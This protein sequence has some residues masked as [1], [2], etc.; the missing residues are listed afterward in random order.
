MAETKIEDNATY[1]AHPAISRTK[2]M[3]FL[4]RRR[5]YHAQY[6]LGREP[7]P[8]EK[9]CIEIGSLGHEVLLED[10]DLES[11]IEV[12]P[13]FTTKA[14]TP[15]KSPKST[16]AY[17]DWCDEVRRSGKVPLMPEESDAIRG[18]INAVRS[19]EFI[20]EWLKLR[21]RC[22]RERSVY[23][24]REVIGVT[25]QL[26]V[27]PDWWFELPD[28][29]VLIDFKFSTDASADFVRRRMNDAYWMQDAMYCDGV[30]TVTDKPTTM[31][32]AFV[33]VSDDPYV[34]IYRNKDGTKMSF[35][36][37]YAQALRDLVACEQSGD[38]REPHEKVVNYIN[39]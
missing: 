16:D 29:N 6:V 5:T 7:E 26:R 8:L 37:A 22:V 14:G 35:H 2:L 18:A 21:H 27:R 17:R 28:Q 36:E 9:T 20:G 23:W 39:L 34:A 11:A 12:A 1:H 4:E 33:E 24:H 13:T 10:R 38:W 32:F 19:H 15:A 30:A 25:K 31:F 3:Q